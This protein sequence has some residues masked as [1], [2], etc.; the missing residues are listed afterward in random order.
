MIRAMGLAA[1]TRE[2]AN[3]CTL[4][5]L[6]QDS[7]VLNLEPRLALSRS[8]RSEAA[9]EKA[10]QDHFNRPL[11]LVIRMDSSSSETPAASMQRQKHERQQEAEAEIIQDATVQAFQDHLDARIVPGSITPID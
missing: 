10:L 7:C 9:L 8:P 6:D 1:M 3:N 5:T 2:L 11:K 4:H